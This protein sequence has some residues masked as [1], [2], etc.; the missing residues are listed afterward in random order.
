M[1]TN[2]KNLKNNILTN[3]LIENNKNTNKE[4][5]KDIYDD[6]FLSDFLDLN[7][8]DESPVIDNFV[9][10]FIV[11]SIE[12]D[13][14]PKNY[15]YVVLLDGIPK[16]YSS[17]LQKCLYITEV[18]VDG[19]KND[20]FYDHNIRV[21]SSDDKITVYKKHKFLIT[22]YESVLHYLEIHPVFFE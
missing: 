5:L 21:E 19:Y 14:K 18:L 15:G 12:K 10:N 20:Y 4:H 1:T 11:E 7:N 8:N 16:F 17:N 9:S 13:E 22:S 2:L 3:M 6:K